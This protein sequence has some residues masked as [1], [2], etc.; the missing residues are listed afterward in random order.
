[1]LEKFRIKKRLTVAFI[2]AACITA[3]GAIAGAVALV[4]VDNRYSYALEYYGFSQGDIG[5]TMVVFA[6][7]RAATRAIISY[8][9][10]DVIEEA[11]E[12]HDTNKANFEDFFPQIEGRLT[13][14]S[15]REAYQKVSDI[16]VQYWKL[17]AEIVE[18]G[19]TLDEEKSA[20]AQE[21]AAS[22]L[23]PLYKEAYGLLK[24]L[25][26]FNI[27]QG[28]ELSTSLTSLSRFLLI[29]IIIVI[30]ISMVIAI[31]LGDKIARGISAPLEALGSRLKTFA[32]GN[33]SEPFPE[34]TT[35]DEVSDMVLIAK[36]MAEKLNLI[37]SDVGVLLGQM[38]D[39]NYAVSSKIG[40]QYTGDFE[41]L[42]TAMAKMR[43]Q[44]NNTLSSIEDASSQVSAGSG[45]LAE[46]SQSLA[47][48]ATDQAGAVEELQ[49][50]ITSITENIKKSAANAQ[51]SYE[52]ARKYADEADHSREEM[53]AMVEAMERIN[54]TSKRIESIISEIEDIASQTNL[55]SLNASI[56][57]ARAGE[58][59]KGFAVVADQI[60]QLAEQSTKSA[61][62]TRELIEGS[63]KEITEGNHAAER[64]ASSIE[65]VV[66]GVKQIAEASKEL[67]LISADQAN[68]MSQAEEGV[69]Q[70]SEV[71]QSNSATAEEAS[72]TSEELSAQA[73]ALDE[74]IGQ[75]TL[76]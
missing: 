71:V 52:Q 20:K 70:I 13:T 6:D 17:D 74:L 11:I 41:H 16:L 31:R 8:M 57:A 21:M 26:D 66:S 63:L 9:D 48:G 25:L 37:I 61:V 23:D 76:Q 42:R 27:T 22:Q 40:E 75:F 29:A 55:L 24:E 64:A 47:E 56:E 15:E 58:A 3:I 18:M 45:N 44:M 43:D 32:D 69:N 4:V 59:G 19:N 38:A 50:T 5:K 62:D 39:G 36:K 1:M 65:T 14:D 54:E 53:K 72:A 7:A 30:V 49:A 2:I 34:N 28:N 51:D 68:A 73:V 10:E 33:L 46:A 67:S 35:Q 60:R 12:E